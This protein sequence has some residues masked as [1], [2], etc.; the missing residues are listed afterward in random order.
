MVLKVTGSNPVVLQKMNNKALNYFFVNNNKI[1]N[2]EKNRNIIDYLENLN[3]K[4]PHYCYHQKLSVAGNC[5][6]CLVELKNSPKPLIACAMTV[7]NKMEIYTNSPLVKKARE[8]VMEFLLLNHPLDCPI[9]DQGG[10]C[11]L[12]DQSMFFGTSKK[13]FYNYKRSVKNKNLGPIVKTVMTRCIHC[14]RCVRFADEIAGVPD[15]GMFGRGRNSEIG[16]YVNKIFKSE[17]SGN[18]ID[19]CPVGA[20]TNKPYS[21]VDRNWEL[22]NVVAIDYNDSFGQEILVSLKSE[23]VI[24]KIQPF[25]NKNDL[26]TSWISDKTRFSFD[27]MFSPEKIL[28]IS[29][30]DISQ[31]QTNKFTWKSIFKE[32]LN[33]IFFQNHLNRYLKDFGKLT[34]IVGENT[35]IE[36]LSILQALEKKFKFFCLNKLENTKLNNDLETHF[37]TNSVNNIDLL[38]K[39]SFCLLIGT[40]TRVESSLLN[41]KLRQRYLQGNFSVYSIGSTLDLTFPVKCLGSNIQILKNISEGNHSIC[42]ELKNAENPLIICNFNSFKQNGTKGILENLN[43]FSKTVNKNLNG[44][45]Y[46]N[47]NLFESNNN[48]LSILKPLNKKSLMNSFGLYFINCNFENKTILK[49]LELKTLKIYLLDKIKANYL[50]NQNDLFDLKRNNLKHIKSI[51]NLPASTFFESSNLYFTT[52]GLLKKTNKIVSNKSLSKNNWEILRKLFS[53]LNNNTVLKKNEILTFNYLKLIYFLKFI[54]LN[55]FSIQTL[56]KSCLIDYKKSNAVL[57]LTK[58][59]RSLYNKIYKTKINFWL[60]DFYIGSKDNYSKFSKVM[61]ESSKFSRFQETNFKYLK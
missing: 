38:N 58:N 50:I 22:T 61:I 40:N 27:G 57:N 10:E 53:L 20:L 30:A 21:F 23:S 8:N 33:V 7:T 42:Q 39:S 55:Y 52:E 35:S 15:L 48:Y 31:K 11:D 44:F 45:N 29:V 28:N 19:I 6:M 18:I 14:T 3:I 59:N 60:N 5:R 43:H 46:I 56:K 17:L 26:S 47:N 4:I 49:L 2:I 9:C 34:F 13:R 54:N 41:I 25:Y 36:V 37:L 51:I 24:T 16:T 12:Q 1:D 32:I